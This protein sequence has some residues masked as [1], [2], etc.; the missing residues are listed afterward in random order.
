MAKRRPI[1]KFFASIY[2]F[3]AWIGYKDIVSGASA[4][5]NSIKVITNMDSTKGYQPEL[6]EDALVRLNLTEAD[7]ENLKSGYFRNF[8]VFLTVGLILAIYSIYRFY[9]GQWL[10]GWISMLLMT[11]IFLFSLS[12]HFW[13]FQIKHRKLGCTLTEWYQSK[14]TDSK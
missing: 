2:N 10:S 13:Y 1:R 8:L 11:V 12:S 14:I 6:F 3:K 9:M 5:T 7:V 4:V